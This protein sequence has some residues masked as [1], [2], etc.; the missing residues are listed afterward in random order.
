MR[1]YENLGN[2]PMRLTRRLLHILLG[3]EV[4]YVLITALLLNTPLLRALMGLDERELKIEISHGFSVVPGWVHLGRIRIHGQDENVDWHIDLPRA[5]LTLRLDELVRKRV[6][7]P[8]LRAPEVSFSL[9]MKPAPEAEAFKKASAQEAL[10]TLEQKLARWRLILDDVRLAQIGNLSVDQLRLRGKARIQG[11]LDLKPGI[12]AKIG[13]GALD[14]DEGRL[15]K[16]ESDQSSSAHSTEQVALVDHLAGH[17]GVHFSSFRIDHIRG[18]DVVE[19]VNA[20]T[21][22]SGK[23]QGVDLL[24]Y[25]FRQIPELK[26]LQADAP[27]KAEVRV[28]SGRIVAGHYRVGPSQMT[29]L[30]RRLMVQGAGS[31]EGSI[32]P[33]GEEKELTPPVRFKQTNRAFNR[34]EIYLRKLSVDGRLT[35]TKLLVADKLH[36]T[37]DTQDLDL[38]SPF[39]EMA[40]RLHLPQSRILDL[41]SWDAAVRDAPEGIHFTGGQGELHAELHAE[42]DPRAMRTLP[43]QKNE[44]G[45]SV[46]HAQGSIKA[47]KLQTRID[48]GIVFASINPKK[49]QALIHSSELR[50]TSTHLKFKRPVGEPTIRH[51]WL[52]LEGGRGHLDFGKEPAFQTQITLRTHSVGPILSVIQEDLKLSKLQYKILNLHL[53]KLGAN[54]RLDSRGFFLQ[55]IALRSKTVDVSGRLSLLKDGT[56]GVIRAKASPLTLGIRFR[57]H[58]SDLRLF[59]GPGFT[60]EKD[61]A[62][63]F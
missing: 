5:R 42:T 48:G 22:L 58:E 41:K 7:I 54:L 60:R 59:P 55:D 31:I 17:I 47:S 52:S 24:G 4:G 26:V 43:H 20:Q 18:K 45:F 15:V 12:E 50:L 62:H 53:V 57:G 1:R 33:E 6:H 28:E 29:L 63:T 39:S 27:L 56:W 61:A 32:H 37:A 19:Y 46:Q 14:I 44:I 8:R 35:K 36:L 21:E 13:P 34:L 16:V 25:Y 40:Y 3:L 11:S 49:D 2:S 9:R 38:R 10:P 30:T 51:W 23:V